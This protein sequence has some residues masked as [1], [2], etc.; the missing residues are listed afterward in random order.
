MTQEKVDGILASITPGLKEDLC[1]DCDL[2][3]EVAENMEVKKT[4]FSELDK[5]CKPECV[6]A[7]NT[8][9]LSITEIGNGLTCPMIGMHFFNPADR[10]KLIEVIAGV[11]T[12]AENVDKIV[13]ISEE[14]GKTPVQV[15]EV[16]GLL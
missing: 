1:A 4:T 13:K 11:N 2:I 12:P 16:A 15:N 14:I 9:S 8:S 5:I 7:S 6:F 10:M 3:V